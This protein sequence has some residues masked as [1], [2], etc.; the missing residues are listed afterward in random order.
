MKVDGKYKNNWYGNH[1]TE[2]AYPEGRATELCVQ[3]SDF[4]TWC[5]VFPYKPELELYSY[6]IKLVQTN[7]DEIRIK[8]T[9]LQDL[10]HRTIHLTQKRVKLIDLIE[11]EGYG[12][13][14]AAR[15]LRVKIPTAK[16]ILS[17]YRKK[18]HIYLKKNDKTAPKQAVE[19][20]VP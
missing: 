1:N 15:Q 7:Y 6:I 2:W 3:S 17:N 8:E 16:V 20:N 13:T 10:L 14:K 5:H 11:K 19:E 18:G 9:I 4:T 12:V